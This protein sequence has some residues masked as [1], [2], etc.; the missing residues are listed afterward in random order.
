MQGD[1]QRRKTNMED[2]VVVNG[3]KKG[4]SQIYHVMSKF[5]P[6]V[7]VKHIYRQNVSDSNN[8]QDIELKHQ[9][10]RRI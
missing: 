10:K 8:K 9:V 5:N 1:G 4:L 7:S 2:K 3:R 6:Q